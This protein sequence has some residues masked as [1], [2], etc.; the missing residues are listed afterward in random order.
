MFEQQFTPSE[1]MVEEL[2]DEVVP[3]LPEK[4]ETVHSEVESFDQEVKI[5][6]VAEPEPVV[7]VISQEISSKPKM[8]R[9]TYTPLAQEFL[10]KLEAAYAAKDGQELSD[11]VFEAECEDEVAK[12]LDLDWYERQ[13]AFLT[14]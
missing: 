6:K 3:S 9:D 13:A 10:E 2:P 5:E 12:Q 11:I 14:K 1:T 7:E 8:M 4:Q